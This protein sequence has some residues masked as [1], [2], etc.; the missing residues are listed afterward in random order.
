MIHVRIH[1]VQYKP[2]TDHNY[3]PSTTLIIIHVSVKS[4]NS[5][6]YERDAGK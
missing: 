4:N 6:H 3:P 1:I 2:W 5:S